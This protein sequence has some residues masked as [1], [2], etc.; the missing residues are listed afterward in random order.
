MGNSF[1][2]C[3]AK[4]VDV[5]KGLAKKRKGGVMWIQGV[6]NTPLV[7][8]ENAPSTSKQGNNVVSPLD[9]MIE[10]VL[11]NFLSWATCWTLIL[12]YELPY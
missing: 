7:P 2:H 4:G 3:K 5:S 10:L 8:S 9:F 6:I 1:S 11:H 12:V